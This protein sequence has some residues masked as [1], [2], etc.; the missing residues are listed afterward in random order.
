VPDAPAAPLDRDALQAHLDRLRQLLATSNT[1]AVEELDA[2]Q[3]GLG[4]GIGPLARLD[5]CVRAFDF[6]GALIVLDELAD[7]LDHRFRL[8]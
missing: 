7:A 8:R 1:D 4:S 6:E 5:E 3:A 2:L